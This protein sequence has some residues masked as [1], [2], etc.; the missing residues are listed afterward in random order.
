MN[1]LTGLRAPHALL[2]CGLPEDATQAHVAETLALFEAALAHD[3]TLPPAKRALAGAP[4]ACLV[5]ELAGINALFRLPSSSTAAAAASAAA[6][7]GGGRKA[8]PASPGG[9]SGGVRAAKLHREWAGFWCT[10][11]VVFTRFSKCVRLQHIAAR[12]VRVFL[13]N[14]TIVIA[15]AWLFTCLLLL[16]VVG[17]QPACPTSAGAGGQAGSWTCAPKKKAAWSA[18]FSFFRAFKSRPDRPR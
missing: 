15:R 12:S 18:A 13:V 10:G 5:A 8:G 2:R 16:G 6:G 11:D 1:G 17:I 4:R 9:L 3:A 14:P 7:G